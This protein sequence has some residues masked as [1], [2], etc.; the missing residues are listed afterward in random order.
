MIYNVYN[1]V[2]CDFNCKFCKI[3]DDCPDRIEE[4]EKIENN[5]NSCI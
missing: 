5:K 4:S 2:V 3:I 1:E